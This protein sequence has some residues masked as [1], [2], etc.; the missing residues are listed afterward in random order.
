M[1]LKPRTFLTY[2]CVIIYIIV[3]Y[4]MNLHM[5]AVYAVTEWGGAGGAGWGMH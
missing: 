3:F 4:S 5:L 1:T 2:T